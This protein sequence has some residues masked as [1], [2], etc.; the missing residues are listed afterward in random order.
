MLGTLTY[1]V[2]AA[3]MAATPCEGLKTPIPAEHD[4]HNGRT[5]AGRCVYNP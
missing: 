5:G 1:A 3:T 4:N 2:M